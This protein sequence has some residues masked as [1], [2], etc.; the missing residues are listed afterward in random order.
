[1]QHD[2]YTW[3]MK[4]NEFIHLDEVDNGSQF[5]DKAIKDW[6]STVSKEQRGEFINKVFE[7][8]QTTDADTI[9]QIKEKWI[10]NA[11]ILVSTYKNMDEESKKIMTKTM[12]ALFVIIKNNVKQKFKLS[13][14]KEKKIKKI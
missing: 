11:K 6:L 14:K 2:V 3:Q 5:I 4:G 10:K 1:M 7:I 13:D 12:E 9:T 8:L